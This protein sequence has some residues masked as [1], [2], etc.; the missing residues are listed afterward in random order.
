MLTSLKVDRGNRRR[1]DVV[2]ENLQMPPEGPAPGTEPSVLPIHHC[3]RS[4]VDDFRTQEREVTDR[5][6]SEAPPG[7]SF[8]TPGGQDGSE[9]PLKSE[10]AP[11]R[12]HSPQQD[13]LKTTIA[14]VSLTQRQHASSVG[15]LE[16]STSPK[17]AELGEASGPAF[18]R[19]RNRRLELLEYG[20]TEKGELA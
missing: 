17:T 16:R 10:T 15:S 6:P 19:W 5:S 11:T 8:S 2:Q 12:S 18:L 7:Y 20:S 9:Q 1:R 4:S 3:L 14:S 13:E